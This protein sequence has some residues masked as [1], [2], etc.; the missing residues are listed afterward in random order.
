MKLFVAIIFASN[1][2]FFTNL[3][4]ETQQAEQ[5]DKFIVSDS[6]E[7]KTDIFQPKDYIKQETFLDDIPMQ[8]Q[9]TV[10]EA[11]AIPG[12]QGDPIKAVKSFAGVSNLNDSSG[13]LIIHASKPRETLT[14]INQLPIGY[15]FHL[16]GRHSVINPS[17][18]E[19]LD[20]F[21]GGFDSVYGNS[22]GA[23]L[24]ITPKYPTTEDGL[25]GSIHVGIYDSSFDVRTTF[26]EDNNT[27]LLLAGRRSYFDLFLP[28]TGSFSDEVT[29]SQFPQFYDGNM[30]LTHVYKNSLFALEVLTA[31]DT[32]KINLEENVKDPAATGK[33][34]S[35]RGFTT[36]GFRWVY[37]NYENYNSNTL[38]YQMKT[39]N[40]FALFEDVYVK[41]RERETGLTH[42]STFRRDKGKTSVGFRVSNF[43]IPLQIFA[44]KQPSRE[45][46]DF[47]FT[48]AEKY[49]VE[50]TL[51]I[52]ALVLY[53]QDIY[54]LTDKLDVKYGFRF[55]T[56]NRGAK[57]KNINPRVSLVYRAN[58]KHSFAGTWGKY[59][60][61]PEGSRSVGEAGNDQLKYEQAIHYGLN[62]KYKHDKDTTF[63]F[64]PYYKDYY[65]LVIEDQEYNYLNAG[66]G[67]ATGFDVTFKKYAK[68]LFFYGVYSFVDSQRSLTTFDNAKLHTFYA[69]I[70]HSLQLSTGYKFNSDIDW[71]GKNWTAS[72]LGQFHNGIPYTP[73]VG[74]YY[75]ETTARW[76]PVYGKAYSERLSNY[77]SLNLKIAKEVKYRS[78]DS[79]E[80]SFELMNATNNKNVG[81]I[82][83]SDDYSTI[84]Y[85]YQ[86]P[87]VPWFDVTYRF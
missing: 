16:G 71:L 64:E 76:R 74:R 33:I 20:V 78:G 87:L 10:D 79:L 25:D 63:I 1:M 37:D 5:L 9:I 40:S 11:L 70:P 56:D 44:P 57:D 48:T 50:E 21:L 69:E 81:S 4:A 58:E 7:N 26:G 3:S 39:N 28:S 42:T 14:V 86:L 61:M 13:E 23:V 31:Y 29:Y 85:E 46:Y 68:N 32:L 36:V 8:Q 47:D 22:M 72:V 54:N 24:D 45:D 52:N 62:Y 84:E 60:Q 41:I 80:W 82:D 75:D 49:M 66:T 15:L 17:A 35:E 38:L 65:D 12:V 83:Y 67:Y 2:L 51:N 55:M 43:K 19:Q 73:V 53:A 30:I 18:I 77:F 27:N 34:E 6:E 59:S